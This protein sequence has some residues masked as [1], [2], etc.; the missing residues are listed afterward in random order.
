MQADQLFLRDLDDLDRR[1]TV[2]DEYKALGAAAL[3]RRL[4][5]DEAPLVHQVNRYRR[6]RIRFR[7]NGESPLER[8][9]LEDN[10]LLWAI[11]DAID[12]DAFPAPGISAPMDAKL[13]QFLARTV[14][15]ARGE[16]LSEG[17]LIRQ[18]AHID[19]GVHNGNPTNPR[20]E[21][22]D[23]VSR[24]MFFRDVPATVHHVQLI[25]KIAVGGLVPLRDVILAG[26]GATDN[27]ATAPAS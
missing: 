3:L 1:T 14:M 7:I 11:G 6:V 23:Q 5:L 20:E 25:G 12:P 21:L 13:N 10:P 24:F 19:G 15:V 22:L 27:G 2:A 4:L 18:V 26:D 9:V 8:A 16:R 17:D